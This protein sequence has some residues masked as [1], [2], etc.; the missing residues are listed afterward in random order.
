VPTDLLSYDWLS[1][2]EEL[3]SFN[4]LLVTFLPS[5]KNSLVMFATEKLDRWEF[6][7]SEN[8]QDEAYMLVPDPARRN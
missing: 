3:L 2:V 7:D 1:R 5:V 4:T 8:I 6:L